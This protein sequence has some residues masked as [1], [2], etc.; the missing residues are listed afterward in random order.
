VLIADWF[1]RRYTEYDASGRPLKPSEQPSE[2]E[3]NQAP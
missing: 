1:E 3:F 2:Q